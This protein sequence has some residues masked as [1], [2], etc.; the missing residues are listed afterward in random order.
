MEAGPNMKARWTKKEPR[1]TKMENEA[2]NEAK[3][4]TGGHDI[5][6]TMSLTMYPATGA[7]NFDPKGANMDQNVLKWRSGSMWVLSTPI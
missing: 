1:Y 4:V 6:L 5:G 7:R 3:K 2:E